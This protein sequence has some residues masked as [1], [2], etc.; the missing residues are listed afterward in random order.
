MTERQLMAKIYELQHSNDDDNTDEIAEI[1]RQLAG[2]RGPQPAPE[3]PGRSEPAQRPERPGR[4][5][6]THYAPEESER[7]TI[8]LLLTD[9]CASHLVLVEY[10]GLEK[11]KR[12]MHALNDKFVH[13]TRV[14]VRYA[15]T[16]TTL[17]SQLATKAKDPFQTFIYTLLELVKT[18]R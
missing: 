11:Q 3:R 5:L 10:L 1:K 2:I 12:Q 18:R 6:R 15:S 9:V 4:S 13:L 17:F 7:K 14:I 16:A 8:L